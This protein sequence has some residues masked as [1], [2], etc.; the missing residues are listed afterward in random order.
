MTPRASSTFEKGRTLE[1]KFQATQTTA[2]QITPMAMA[3]WPL[4]QP[5]QGVIP[6]SPQI[7]PFT[8]PRKVG[9]FSLDSQASRAIQ[10]S[11]PAAVARLVLTTAA[12]ASAPAY[13]GSPPLKPFQPSHRMPAPTAAMT[14]LL[15]KACCR[16]RRS[17]GPRTQAATNPDTPADIW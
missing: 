7:M 17:R 6:T 8:P 13:Y 2:Q 11:T 3:P 9:F 4:T 1:R 5:A 14:R 12:A 16:S 15:G 10:V